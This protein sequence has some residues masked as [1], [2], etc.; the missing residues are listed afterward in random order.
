MAAHKSKPRNDSDEVK[1]EQGKGHFEGKRF[2][3]EKLVN[4]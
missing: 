2:Q 3:N 4:L 1:D